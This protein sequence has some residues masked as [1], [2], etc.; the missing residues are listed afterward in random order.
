MGGAGAAITI[1]A[2][3]T[4]CTLPELAACATI[5]TT[6]RDRETSNRPG[7]DSTDAL[8]NLKATTTNLTATTANRA[9]V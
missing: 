7:R 3:T 4:E 2:P 9:E 5:T 1:R 8:E 6:T